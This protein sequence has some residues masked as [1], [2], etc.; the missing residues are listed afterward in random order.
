MRTVTTDHW[1][2]TYYLNQDRGELIDRTN[3]PQEMYNLWHSSQHQHIKQELLNHLLQQTLASI[4][5]V[6]G[7]QQQ[8]SAPIP[9]WRQEIQ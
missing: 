5:M 1:R 4:D 6:N 3:D 7:R 9:K 2:L 8:P